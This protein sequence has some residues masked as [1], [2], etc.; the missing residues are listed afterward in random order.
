HWPLH[1]FPEDIAK[2]RGKYRAG[3]DAIRARRHQRQKELGVVAQNS[4]LAPRPANVPA[5]ETIPA[6]EQDD[7]DLRMAIYAAQIDRMDRGIGRVLEA[8]RTAGVE[9]D[10][11]VIFLSDNGGAPETPRRSLPGATLGSRESYESY[12]I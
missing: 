7:W 2:Y 12:G 9:R 3:W 6:A 8:L 1:A 10:T 11:L 4:E 5:W